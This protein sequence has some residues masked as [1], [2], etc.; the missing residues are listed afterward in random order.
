[1][2]ATMRSWLIAALVAVVSSTGWV[3]SA[4]AQDRPAVSEQELKAAYLYKFLAY[5]EWPGERFASPTAPLVVGVLGTR[6]LTDELAKLTQGKTV[7]QRPIAVR[8]LEQAGSLEGLHVLFV[9]SGAVEQL[10]ALVPLGRRSSVLIVTETP[11]ALSQG[12]VINLVR[13]GD[14]ISFEVSLRGAGASRL[15]LNAGLLRVAERVEQD[16]P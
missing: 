3:G 6:Q 15:R 9:T 2:V 5:V 11:N 7:G 10:P 12:S 13:A 16:R 14:R 8:H 1:M 4:A